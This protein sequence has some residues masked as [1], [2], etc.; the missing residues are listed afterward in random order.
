[1]RAGRTGENAAAPIWRRRLLLGGGLLVA[2]AVVY[3][4]WAATI[5]RWWA[6]RVGNMV[7]GHLS[8]GLLLGLVFG[9]CFT[10][11][12]LLAAWAGLHRRRPWKVTLAWLVL[13]LLLAMPN[14]W[15]LGIAVGSGSAAHAGE[16]VMDV[17]AP[18][19]RGSTLI[20]AIIAAVIFAG[21]MVFT[22][23]RWPGRGKKPGKGRGNGK[24][25][26]ESAAD[27]PGSAG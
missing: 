15:T 24:D 13:A 23:A 12:P 26:G 8:A 5:P 2:G 10:L 25:H 14:L 11:L 1:M 9:I 19:F 21:L 7:N 6:Q 20:G 3:F 27:E 18:W 4:A 16:R 22:R 17:R